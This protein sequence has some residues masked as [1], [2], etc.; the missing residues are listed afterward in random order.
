MPGGSVEL[1]A[2]LMTPARWEQIKGLFHATLE[3]EPAQRPTFLARACADD[4]LLRLEVESLLASHE[5]AESF[6][7]MPASDVA[8]ELL[9]EESPGLL[10]GQMLGHFRIADVLAT[11]GMGEVYLAD[12]MRLGRKVAL[13]LLPPQFTINADRVRRF[14]QEARAASALNHPNI[15]T[16][17]EIGHTD[18]HHFI[19]TEFVDGETLREHMSNV[20]MKL[21]EVLDIATQIA[22]AL[23]AAHAAGIV[24]RDIKPE[25]VMIRPDGY[26]KV[27]DFGLA[28]LVEQK[29]TSFLGLKES[30]QSASGLILGTVNYMSPEQAKGERVDERTDIFSFGVVLYE[31]LSGSTPFVGDSTSETFANLINAEPRPLSDSASNVPAELKRIVAKA[32]RKNKD[33]RYQ[34]VKDLLSDFKDLRQ[35]LTLGDKLERLHSPSDQA[36]SALE[37]ATV[38]ANKQTAETQYSFSHQINR[39]K[40]LAVF[41]LAALLICSIGLGYYFFFAGIAVSGPAGKKSFAVLPLKPINAANRH[42]IYEIGIADSLI[43]KINSTKGFVARPLSATRK[44]TDIEQDPIAAGREQQVDYVIASTYQLADGKIRITAQLLNVASGLIEEPYT[45]EK[46]AANA[47]A[48]QDAIASDLSNKLLSRFGTTSSRPTAQR[49]TTNE[50]AYLSYLQGRN[51]TYNRT[52]ADAPKSIEYFQQAINLDPNF[53]RAYA[54]MAHAYIASGNLRGGSR[55]DYEKAKEAVSKALSLDNTLADGYA[56]SGELKHAI[57]WDYPAAE[58]DLLHAIQ[59]EPN[60]DFAH[61]QYASYLSAL[62]RFDE[63]LEQL[64]IALEIDPNSY[65]TQRHRG[66]I[67]YLARRYDE[68][69]LQFKR[70][71]EVHQDLGVFGGWLWTSYELKGDQARAYEWFIKIHNRVRPDLVPLF[72]QAYETSGWPGVQQKVFELQLINEQKGSTNYYGMAR[73]CALI[74][75]KELA[76]VYLNKAAENHAGQLQMLNVE[77]P[78]DVLRDDPR[79]EELVRRVGLK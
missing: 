40:S 53:A 16:I 9:A 7:E 23:A 48:M 76:F 31:M 15:V 18:S 52:T 61:E 70:V 49:G 34:T 47:F 36:T 20:Q 72:Q 71:I 22:S 17:H 29:N 75:K 24:H 43:Q 65:I 66:R 1:G 62:G 12:D 60:S 64:R 21:D 11:G 50:E 4:G 3:R 26:V 33:E 57:E 37:A 19:A 28:K 44:Y 59:L 54:R 13:K 41:V 6:I 32:L 67:L 63:A 79:F 38:D 56:V 8:A 68:A 25:N 27:L 78:F 42:Q 46:D 51:L 30:T 55:V 2:A 73:Q 74:G 39:H 77:P 69:I 5:Q 45:I 14:E 58:K 35:H 10:A